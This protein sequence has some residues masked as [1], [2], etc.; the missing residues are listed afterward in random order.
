MV[1][2]NGSSDAL[3]RISVVNYLGQVLMDKFVKPQGRITNYRTWVSGIQPGHMLKAE[4]F[5]EILPKIHSLLKDK[6]IVGHSL[7]NDFKVLGYNTQSF[8]EA[9]I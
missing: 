4:P 2:V 5:S 9:F 1:E 7:K 3:A 8:A 6:I